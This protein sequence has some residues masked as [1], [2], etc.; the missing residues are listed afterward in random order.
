MNRISQGVMRAWVGMGTR[1]LPFADAATPDLPLSRLLRLSLFQ[2]SVG[3]CLVLM[4]GTLNRVMIVELGV[5]ASLVSIMVA[6]PL[7][8]AP[9]RALIGF[10]SDTHRSQLGWKRVP[11]IYR[12]TMIQFGGLSIMPF[13]L[14]V[15]SGGGNSAGM[16]PWVGQSAAALS[17]LLVGVGMHTTQTV[18]LALATDLASPESRPKVVGLMYTMLMFGTI[19]SALIFGSLLEDFTPGRLIQVIQGAAVATLILNSVAIWKQETR[20]RGRLAQPAASEP[21]FRESWDTFI[22]GEHA[23]RRLLA[24]G[25]GT[26][27]FSMSDVLLEPYGGEILKLS[28]GDTTKLTATLAVGGLLG[29]GLASRVLSFGADPFRMASRGALVGV[30][31]FA[32]V[33]LAA[34]LD[35]PMLFGS[36]ILFVGFGAGLFAHG[37]LTATMNLAPADQTGLALGAWGAVQ[38]T[39]AGVGVAAGGIMRD[40]VTAAAPQGLSGAVSGYH[41]VYGV[42]V[43]FLL[44]TLAIMYP[45]INR[46]THWREQE[47]PRT[48]GRLSEPKEPNGGVM[49]QTINRMYNSYES[50]AKAAEELRTNRFIRFPDVFVTDRNGRADPQASGAELSVDEIMAALMKAYVL[51]ADA[52]V[53][54]QRIKQGSALLTVHAQFGSM[55]TALRLLDRHKSVDSGVPDP[56]YVAVPW[57]EAAPCSSALQLPVLLDDSMTFSRFWGVPALTKKGSTSGSCLG[58]PEV[59]DGSRPFTGTFGMALISNKPTILSS[60][61]GLPVLTKSKSS[62]ARR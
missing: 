42:E 28:V 18:G 36:A 44:A 53:Y 12:G 54:A 9:F 17:F 60:A 26:M 33:M 21:T 6:V 39:A 45:L 50:A 52:K 49:T 59:S 56:E 38:A 20:G 61:L 4:V 27:A 13:A 25:L 30:P 19:A 10:R 24:V 8:F 48:S 16:P 23:M 32:C 58:L 15:L 55:A 35:I 2:V 22:Q 3:M 51:K 41:F 7:L 57:D 1:F 14:L 43:V 34:P 29:F 47:N 37:T 40:V 31:A 11:F 46:R 5:S 62:S